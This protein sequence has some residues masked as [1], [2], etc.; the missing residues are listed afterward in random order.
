MVV[1]IDAVR[2]G[3]GFDAAGKW[4]EAKAGFLPAEE[5]QTRSVDLAAARGAVI[6]LV[7]S[8]ALWV[9]LAMV[10]RAVLTLTR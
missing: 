6:G 4:H 9:G 10:V 1:P 8:G 2:Y 5:R 3:A 7:L